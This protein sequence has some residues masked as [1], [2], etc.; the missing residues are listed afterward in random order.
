MRIK[1]GKS[2]SQRPAKIL[3]Y[4]AYVDPAFIKGLTKAG[5]S[6]VIARSEAD[7]RARLGAE[8]FSLLIAPMVEAN[9]LLAFKQ[10]PLVVPVATDKTQHNPDFMFVLHPSP[11]DQQAQMAVIERALEVVSNHRG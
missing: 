10:V 1:A 3:V 5:H 9:R 6:I 11:S 4:S 8:T 2:K 7:V